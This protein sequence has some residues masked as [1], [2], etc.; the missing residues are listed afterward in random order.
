MSAHTHCGNKKFAEDVVICETLN[1]AGVHC[2][3]LEFAADQSRPY[4][5]ELKPDVTLIHF[6]YPVAREKR[7]NSVQNKV[8]L[9]EVTH[10]LRLY[11][12]S[13]TQTLKFL[14]FFESSY[15]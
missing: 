14:Y 3:D 6:K 1:I 4:I 8:T 7:F 15:T 12:K 5:T 10:E 2:I 13:F 9:M 11:A